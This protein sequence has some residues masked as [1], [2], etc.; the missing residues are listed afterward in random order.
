M[1]EEYLEKDRVLA[2]M[3]F[4]IF[5]TFLGTLCVFIFKKKMTLDS[6]SKIFISIYIL[7]RGINMI[8]WILDIIIEYERGNPYYL[9]FESVDFLSTYIVTI[10]LYVFIIDMFKVKLLLEAVSLENHRETE[11]RVF[12]YTVAFMSI[13]IS[14]MFSGTAVVH[15]GM[16]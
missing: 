15:L 2:L 5:L 6:K 1:E 8:N 14:T 11:T 13:A 16:F 12:K 3:N 9:L 10:A 4:F 7:G